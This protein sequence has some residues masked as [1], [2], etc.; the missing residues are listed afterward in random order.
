MLPQKL[1]FE[2]VAPKHGSNGTWGDS[3][4]AVGHR[5]YC[6]GASSRQDPFGA[7][8]S[9]NRC[10]WE[11]LNVS[12]SI[13]PR[14]YHSAALVG[15]KIYFH[16]G[17][18]YGTGL[19]VQVFADLVEFDIVLGTCRTIKPSDNEYRKRTSASA[20]Y[21]SWRREIVVYGGNVFH[22]ARSQLADLF[23]ISVDTLEWSDVTCKGRLPP[24]RENH[25]AV[26]DKFNMF[27]FG[28]LNRPSTFLND[29]WIANL[30]DRSKITWS[31]VE[32]TGRIPRGRIG[33]CLTRI[34]PVM[35]LLG[36]YYGVAFADIDLY[37]Y[38]INSSEWVQVSNSTVE[39]EGQVPSSRGKGSANINGDI[40][41]LK[42]TGAYKLTLT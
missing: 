9:V 15:D 42:G 24:Q 18:I 26:L 28:G 13:Q 3:I 34:G 4:T 37:L 31:M 21:A 14:R 10:S 11:V 41:Y 38:V 5:I 12:P 40:W 35:V 19:P 36:G 32:C 25:T 20:V 33:A 27:I 6:F 39:L 22:G 1:K 30:S 23:T 16:G 8:F 2:Q 7:V 29:L 17:Q